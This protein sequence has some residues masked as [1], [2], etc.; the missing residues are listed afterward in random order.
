MAGRKI[1]SRGT[2]FQI[3]DG[4]QVSLWNDPWLPLPHSFK[5]YSLPMEGTELWNVGDI[6]DQEN[7][8][9]IH[10]VITELFTDA[11]SD[12][13]LQIP[14]SLRISEDRVCWHFDKHDMYNVKSGYHI[15]QLIASNEMQGSSFERSDNTRMNLWKKVWSAHVP[16]KVRVF[17]W[18]LLLG[19]L[20]TRVALSKKFLIPEMHCVFCNKYDESDAHVFMH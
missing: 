7:H 4:H 2:R 19:N 20:P 8:S 13:I 6:I 12:I 10:S 14:L 15:A 5:P 3:G 18:R 11:D 16:P 9:W 1:L 17:M